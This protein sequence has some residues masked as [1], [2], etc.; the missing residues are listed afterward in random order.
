MHYQK[1]MCYV[2]DRI[3][4][5]KSSLSTLRGSNQTRGLQGIEDGLHN[6]KVKIV[7]VQRSITTGVVAV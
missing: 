5:K 2:I 6:Q 7:H 1:V 3:Q 4:N